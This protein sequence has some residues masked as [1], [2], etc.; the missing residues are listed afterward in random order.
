MSPARCI[1]CQS[2]IYYIINPTLFGLFFLVRAH[3]CFPVIRLPARTNAQA[4]YYSSNKDLSHFVK[5][6][7]EGSTDAG[8]RGKGAELLNFLSG[9]VIY[10]SRYPGAKYAN[11]LGLAI[12]VPTSYTASYDALAWAN[13]SSWTTSS[14]G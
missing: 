11:A 2:N 1:K 7:D 9:S 5:L 4:F 3:G 14:S 12:Y 8:V 13:D 10:H 6:V